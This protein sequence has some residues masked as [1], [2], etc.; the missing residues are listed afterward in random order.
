M[1]SNVIKR[2]G[3]RGSLIIPKHHIY[4]LMKCQQHYTKNIKYPN[5]TYHPEK[6]YMSVILV[7]HVFTDNVA[8]FLFCVRLCLCQCDRA[9]VCVCAR[10]C[11]CA[12]AS[13][14]VG[15][16]DA[17]TGS[18]QHSCASTRA[19][20]T[21]PYLVAHTL[22]DLRLAAS[23]YLFLGTEYNYMEIQYPLFTSTR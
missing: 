13:H 6:T 23:I 1:N 14:R 12:Q 19:Q 4:S 16:L 5:P 9:I 8:L 2:N 3:S 22:S 11:M 20:A 18:S 10:A 21:F 15:P 7:K 17:H